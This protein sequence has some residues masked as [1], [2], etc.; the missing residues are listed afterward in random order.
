MYTAMAARRCGAQVTMLGPRP[1]PCPEVFEPVARHLEAWIGEVVSPEE[2]PRFEISYRGGKTKYLNLSLRASR[3]LTT[4]MLPADLSKYDLVHVTQKADVSDQLPFVRACRRGGARLISSGTHPGDAANSPESVREVIRACDFFFMNLREVRAVFGS[5]EAASV[6]PGKVLFVTMGAEGA[7]V[8]QGD[9]S[10]YVPSVPAKVVDPTGAGDT[11]C[12]ATLTYLMGKEHP[13]MAAQHAIPL[14]A[15][16]IEAVGPTAL[17]REEPAP[18]AA[19]D[20]RVQINNQQV[21]KFSELI[22]TSPQVVKFPFVSPVLPPVGHPK[23]LDYFTAV[24]LQQFC[25]W[26][27]DDGHYTGPMIAEIGSAVWKGSDYLFEAYRRRLE[28]EPDF[29]SP[30]RQANLRREDLL[31]VFRADNAEDPMPYLDLHLEM[32]WNYGRDMMALKLTPQDLVENALASEKPLE[33]FLES[34]DHVGG[35]KEDP[36]RKKSSLL[37]T[38]LN[39][40]PERFLPSREDEQGAPVMDYHVMRS[41]LRIG[42]IEVVDEDLKTKLEER[43]ILQPD[44]EWA[45][46]YPAY[47]AVEKVIKSSGKSSGE[48]DYFLFGA[49]KRCPEMAEPDCGMCLVDPVCAHRKE[50]FQ[51]VMVTSFY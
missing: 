18:E 51:P 41:C 49:R 26:Y 22:S 29:F 2:L 14:A 34:L 19:F 46:R 17:L 7:C 43:K 32:T 4:D 45:V 44:E 36:L 23:S 31:E 12:G 37:A 28:Q 40:R 33:A 38:I 25:F 11:F 13:I 47:L 1:D 39:Q 30:G 3:R 20:G 24:T 5:L 50:L 9:W 21:R 42:L 16:M 8:I 48:V 15:E 35:Y 6:E 10:T 27:Q